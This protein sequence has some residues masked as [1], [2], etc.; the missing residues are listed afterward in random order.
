MNNRRKFLEQCA[1]SAFGVT[2]LSGCGESKKVDSVA[3]ATSESAESPA[4]AKDGFGS[5]KRV[6]FINVKGG[7]SH[8][9]TFDPKKRNGPG[10]IIS[11]KADFQVTNYLEKTAEVADQISLIRSMTAKVGV[12]GPAQYFMRTAFTER[13][14]IK[15]PNLGAWAQHFLGPSHDTLPSSA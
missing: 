3:D 14:T 6:I 13:N 9:D 10:D 8:I 11:S 7:M 15:H 1:F 5:A 2:V 4:T 12:H